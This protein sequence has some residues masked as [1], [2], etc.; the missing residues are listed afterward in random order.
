MLSG[1]YKRSPH[2]FHAPI[3]KSGMRKNVASRVGVN[4]RYGLGP[5][6]KT[7]TTYTQSISSRP[8][9]EIFDRKLIFLHSGE[10]RRAEAKRAEAGISTSTT[11]NHRPGVQRFKCHKFATHRNIMVWV[12]HKCKINLPATGSTRHRL[13]SQNEKPAC[14]R[15][16]YF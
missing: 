16:G 12:W 15:F 9:Q 6:G 1:E 11:T 14:V 3:L 13:V 4:P 10:I 7:G 5:H 8:K 2:F